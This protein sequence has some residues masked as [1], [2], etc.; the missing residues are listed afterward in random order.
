MA[1]LEIKDVTSGYGDVQILWGSTLSL[2]QGKL[3]CLVGGNGVGKTTLLRTILGLLRP[4]SGT[5]TFDGTDVS[6][7]PAGVY[8]LKIELKNGIVYTAKLAKE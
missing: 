8:I 1:L 5:I 2:E 6:K 3:T 7:L 4:W